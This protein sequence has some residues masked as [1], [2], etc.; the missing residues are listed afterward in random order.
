MS[1][2]EPKVQRAPICEIRAGY[3][4]CTHHAVYWNEQHGKLCPFC[5]AEKLA[6]AIVQ[7][8]MNQAAERLAERA[9][10]AAGSLAAAQ[11]MMGQNS[12]R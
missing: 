5:D 9:N 11:V 8:A 1:T 2:D 7:K 12:R 6:G 3:L 4:T 10:E